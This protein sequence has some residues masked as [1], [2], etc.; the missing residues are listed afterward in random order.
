MRDYWQKKPLLI[1]QAIPNMQPLITRQA[2][3]ELAAQSDVES[4]LVT[5]DGVRQPWQLRSG[6]FKPRQLPALK[7]SHWTLLVQGADLHSDAL[8][9]LRERF[10][11]IPDARLDDVMV[12]YASDGGGVGPHFDSYD[13]FLLQAHGQRRWRIG[14]QK[15]LSLRDDLPLKI[16]A[17]FKPTQTWLLEPGDMLYLP[18]QYAHEGV[19]VG[20]CMTYSIGFKAETDQSLGAALISR[21][22]DFEPVKPPVTYSDPHQLAT[23]QPARIPAALQAFAHES[24]LQMLQRDA[25]IRCALGE[26]LSEPKPQVWFDSRPRPRHLTGVRLD[27]KTHMLYDQDFVFI[28][29]ES[30]RCKGQDARILRTLADRRCLEAADMELASAEVRKLLLEWL[31]A[32]WLNSLPVKK[33][34]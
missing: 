31:A 1:R 28:N 4:R 3:F 18:P 19:A 27:R 33:V 11:F 34:K 13:V 8:A 10:R 20:E 12:S 6:P 26:W 29:G 30:W 14:A 23:R 24:V 17:R 22:A 16:L 25:D 21:L 5:G 2:L 15:N 9:Q 7:L 32:G